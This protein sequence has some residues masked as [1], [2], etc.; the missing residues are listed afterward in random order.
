MIR[1]EN[2]CVCGTEEDPYTAPEM[3]IKRLRGEVYGHSRFEDGT[4]ITSSQLVMI[5]L[6]EMRAETASGSYY[7]L[8]KMEDPYKRWL[9]TH[10]PD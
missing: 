6:K 8:G 7:Q 10:K 9:E 5:D 1:I 4:V 3:Q 2:W